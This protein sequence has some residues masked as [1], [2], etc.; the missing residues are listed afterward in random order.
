MAMARVHS[1]AQVEEHLALV[2]QSPASGDHDWQLADHEGCNEPI[3]EHNFNRKKMLTLEQG[4]NKLSRAARQQNE[5]VA[6]IEGGMKSMI[7]ETDLR[8]AIGL[9]FQEFEQRLEDAFQDSNRKC[10]AM[11]SKRDEVCELETLISKKVNWVE[12]NAVL[13]KVSDLR[14]YLDTMAEDIFIGHREALNGEFAKKADKTMVEDALKIK[15]DWVEVN[16]VRAR[17]ERLE[18]L[19]QHTDARHTAAVEALREQTVA[20]RTALAEEHRAL[21]G[22]NA[23][24]VA[25]LRTEHAAAVERL[26]GAEREIEVLTRAAEKLREV[27]QALS[28][29]HDEVIMPTIASMQEQLG[30]V[31]AA[32]ERTRQGLKVLADECKGFQQTATQKFTDLFAQAQHCKEQIEFLMQATEMIKR[33]SRETSKSTDTRFKEGSEDQERLAQQVAALEKQLKRHEREVRQLERLASRADNAATLLPLPPPPEAAPPADPSDRL[34]G[35]LEQLEKIGG[36]GP[37]HE[38]LGIPWNAKRP[39]LPFG[40]ADSIRRGTDADFA[41]LQLPGVDREDIAPIDSA[42]APPMLASARTAGYSQSPRPPGQGSRT[43]R[44]KR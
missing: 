16:E 14:M 10:L 23:A 44:K 3:A 28:N 40:G 42:R 19:V 11:F 5:V 34:R 4:I 21:I 33:R 25:A 17:L 37:P 29:K 15:A 13:K 36:S 31:E 38:Q 41:K 18:V 24:S 35:V 1:Q 43:P 6:Q 20:E 30:E 39:P 22:E 7:S 2:P 12:Y 27:Q 26:G 32:A 8:R 9:A